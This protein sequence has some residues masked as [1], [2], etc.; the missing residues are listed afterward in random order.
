[1][2]GQ[3]GQATVE[4]TGL[5]LLVSVALGATALA[6]RAV[7]AG[8]LPGRVVCAVIAEP[9]RPRPVFPSPAG[10]TV[11][12]MRARLGVRHAGGPLGSI[13]AALSGRF[14]SGRFLSSAAA[15]VVPAAAALEDAADFLWRH[16]R[17]VRKV[18][19]ATAIG[20][21]VAATCAAAIVAANAI[22]ALGCSSAIVGGGFATYDNATR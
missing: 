17:T 10:A 14:P 16:R 5:L 19:V 2:R 21:G 18:L 6:A 1:M 8:G 20:T 11:L 3:R 13:D 22:G 15:T 9:C 4:W 12:G 7:G